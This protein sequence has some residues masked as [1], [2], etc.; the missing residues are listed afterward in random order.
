M[1]QKRFAYGEHALLQMEERGISQNLV[2]KAF[3]SPN[4]I[5]SAKKGRQRLLKHV[6]KNFSLVII[7]RES[8]TAFHI[9]T[10]YFTDKRST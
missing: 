4:D 6:R 7:F 5:S 2:E 9:I 8:I 10:A 3:V 1:R